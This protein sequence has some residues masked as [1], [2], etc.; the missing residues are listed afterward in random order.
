MATH[1]KKDLDTVLK[2]FEKVGKDLGVLK[3]RK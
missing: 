1:T 3:L 2:V